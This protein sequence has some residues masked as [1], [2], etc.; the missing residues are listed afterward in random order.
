[1]KPFVF[2]QT[3]LFS[4]LPSNV[5]IGP[6]K[7]EIFKELY[8]IDFLCIL[9]LYT[10]IYKI[11]RYTMKVIQHSS[12]PSEPNANANV[13]LVFDVETNGLL[14]TRGPRPK[15]EECP[16]I[17]QLSYAMYDITS[18]RLIKTVDAF[19]NVP[20]FVCISEE[21][22][23][24]NGITKEKCSHGCPI[25]V[26][27][28]EFYQDYHK[29][30]VCIAHNY[31]FDSAMISIEF[32]RNW[33]KMWSSHPYALNLFQYTYM[34]NLPMH[35]TCTMLDSVDLCK[36][37]HSKP[38]KEGK[39]QTFKWPT[40]IQLHAY[41]LGFEPSGM[42]NSMMDVLVTLRCYL[43]MKNVDIAQDDFAQWCK[44]SLI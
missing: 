5:E 42:H 22:T 39:P 29:S 35:Y 9:S 2:L 37:P 32:Q 27:L 33:S 4:T 11:H 8:K 10:Q 18:N 36:L 44:T 12:F 30:T 3:N 13:A 28:N 19:I 38:P 7:K 31:K 6:Q 20:D 40:L 1:M 34:K 17:L 14:N 25:E 24:I 21:V 43:K 41:L 15:I 16:Y 23:K 26:A